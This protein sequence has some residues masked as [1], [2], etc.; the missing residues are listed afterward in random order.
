MLACNY[1]LDNERRLVL[2]FRLTDVA[3]LCGHVINNRMRY[4]F[5]RE[6]LGVINISLLCFTMLKNCLSNC[7]SYIKSNTMRELL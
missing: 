2:D 6:K 1:Q 7:N 3:R 4:V 5:Q